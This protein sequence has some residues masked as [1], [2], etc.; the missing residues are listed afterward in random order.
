MQPLPTAPSSRPLSEPIGML[1][2]LAETGIRVI[3]AGETMEDDPKMESRIPLGVIASQGRFEYLERSGGGRGFGPFP[4]RVAARIT[5]CSRTELV[6]A[7]R[8]QRMHLDS[9]R[10]YPCRPA[11]Q[12]LLTCIP[13]L[14]SWALIDFRNGQRHTCSAR[15]LLPLSFAVYLLHGFQA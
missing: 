11:N 15:S 9:D 4:S 1:T 13:V 5:H 6:H 2:Q 12:A 7:C 8:R 14:L 3:L 10:S